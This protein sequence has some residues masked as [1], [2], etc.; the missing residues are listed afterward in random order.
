MKGFL[1][2]TKG[3]IILGSAGVLLAAVIALII[4]LI[5]KPQGYRSISV[6]EV[7]GS[8]LAEND[9]KAYSAYE[10]MRIG[11][12]YA[13]ITETDSYTRLILD[14]DKY[15][16]LEQLSRATFKELGTENKRNTVIN[17]VSGTL[18][19]EIVKPLKLEE[20]Y[21]IN[22]PNAVLSVRGTYFRTEVKRDTNGDY[23]TDVYT[24]GGTVACRR[25]MPDGSIV[26]EEVLIG[27]GYKAC[28][29]MDEIITV[30]VEELIEEGED[31]VD[32]FNIPDMVD[33]DLVGA[34]NASANGH[35]MFRNTED[36]WNEI[37]HRDIDLDKYKSP[38]DNEE[39]PPYVK[40][41]ETSVST[42]AS[43][44]SSEET[45]ASSSSATPASKGTTTV[46]STTVP[47]SG[48]SM[49]SGDSGFSDDTAETGDTDN[50]SETAETET[51]S[52]TTEADVQAET[53]T[54]EES[55]R[56]ESRG[57]TSVSVTS[58]IVTSYT[59][60]TLTEPVDD[61]YDETDNSDEIDNSVTTT[62]EENFVEAEEESEENIVTE[63]IDEDS[64]YDEDF[65][66]E[67]DLFDYAEPEDD[68]EIITPSDESR[69]PTV[70]S[71][72]DD[73]VE[74]M[75]STPSYIYTGPSVTSGTTPVTLPADD[76]M[77]IGI[78]VITSIT[79]TTTT[80]TTTTVTSPEAIIEHICVFENYISDNNATCTEDGTKT[81]VCECGKTD[82]VTDE[83]S[84][85]G[86]T[87]KS[88]TTEA[89]CTEAGKTV[90]SCETCGEVISETEIPALGHTEVEETK[91]ATFAETGLYVK[92]CSVCDELLDRK[93]L[94]RL[95]ALYT[96]DGDITITSTGYTQG[97]AAAETAFTD[98]YV[99]SQ[100]DSSTAV[101]CAIAIES[102]THN[103]K[104]DGVNIELT[105]KSG[106]MVSKDT[107]VSFAGTEALN[108]I[109]ICDSDIN[110]VNG[111]RN[112][113]KV[114]FSSGKFKFNYNKYSGYAVY[115]TD[116][117]LTIDGGAV[118]IY[119]ED[120]GYLNWDSSTVINNGLLSVNASIDGI[121]NWD[122]YFTLNGGEVHAVSENDN[123]IYTDNVF[124][125]NNGTLTAQGVNGI[126]NSVNFK[127]YNGRV[128]L[129]GSSKG[130]NNIVSFY[131][132]ED[133]GS[134]TPNGGETYIEGGSV[135]IFGGVSDI[136]NKNIFK[137]SGGSVRLA[138]D[139]VIG[140]SPII[141][142][143]T[144][145][146]ECVIY[147]TFPT[148][149]ERTFTNSD[150]TSY[151]YALDEADKA[152]DGKYYIWKPVSVT[153]EGL[154]INAVNFPD[155]VFRTYVSNNF[156]TDGNGYLSDE[157]IA[158]VTKIDVSGSD[159]TDGGV[160]SLTGIEHFTALDTLYCKF[161]G[162]LTSLDTS[163][164]TL[165]RDINCYETGITAFDFSSNT[166]LTDINVGHTAIIELDVT[167]NTELTT[168][169]FGTNDVTAI[170][171]SD[172]TKLTY[173]NCGENPLAE[174]DV[175]SNPDLWYLNFNNTGV[176]YID[177]SN[178]TELLQIHCYNCALT[179]ADLTNNT[180]LGTFSANNNK[181]SI[182]SNAVSFDT[183]LLKDFDPTKVSDVTNA[184]FDAAAGVFRMIT[185]DVTYTYDCGQ[186]FAPTFTLVRTGEAT[187]G[188]AVD[189]VNFPD[190]V[191]RNYVSDNFDTDGSG[192]LSDSEVAA[193]TEIDVIGE[194]IYS[195][196]GVEYFTELQKLYCMYTGITSLDVSK[197]TALTNLECD[198][199][200]ITNLDLSKNTA[201]TV[202]YC[203]GTGITS[204]DVSN[205]TVL[206]TLNCSG[207]AL[208]YIDLTNN[209]NLSMFTVFDSKY[210]IPS[211]ATTFDT[212]TIDG[213]DPSK[214]SD[215]T[216]ADLDADT[217]IF[218]N[219]TDD[220]TYTYDCGQGY[221]ETFTL[222]RTGEAVFD[223]TLY[224]EDGNINITSTGVTQG[225][226]TEETAWTGDY[227]ISQR[228]SSTE[229]ECA[230]DITDAD[231]TLDG[232]N[233]TST[234]SNSIITASGKRVT[235]FGTD[236]SNVISGKYGITSDC[237]YTGDGYGLFLE[238][239]L[240]INTTGIGIEG[241]S[242]NTTMN[243]GSISI[244]SEESSVIGIAGCDFIINDG[245]LKMYL[246]GEASEGFQSGAIINGGNVEI[247][248]NGLGICE[249][250]MTG[251]IATIS[252]TDLDVGDDSVI[253]GGSLRLI[254]NS[255]AKVQNETEM[256]YSVALPCTN[257]TTVTITDNTGVI[258]TEYDVN[259]VH[260]DG[261]AY[262]WLPEGIYTIVSDGITYTVTV[263]P[264]ETTIT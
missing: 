235:I 220:I 205:N 11:G 214:V 64:I 24:Y 51:S 78:P 31:K 154:E 203:G 46:I 40:K 153:P 188:I 85:T 62:E 71:T 130:I 197:N 2:T 79:T 116:A 189:S 25:I 81:A 185:G 13:L 23:Y 113:G 186:G 243:S 92:Y 201:L 250:N 124:I 35:K 263:T 160:A 183:S 206:T 74:P 99:I 262:I 140:D 142:N 178:N 84:A 50:D 145:E 165:L 244:Y 234:S 157:E 48:M 132:V 169:I 148:E 210:V 117:S 191:F 97:E 89:T 43:E 90:V 161:N 88:T 118:E 174:L 45:F 162:A 168:L 170:D 3:K 80:T 28:V 163:K 179:C 87:E 147:D 82:T 204:L 114:N 190:E 93:P 139:T 236:K 115:N 171:L 135:F 128:N 77:P 75:I 172:N 133:D 4:F 212:S 173:L 5:N 136:L 240:T 39:I 53:D 177:V 49:S 57:N 192:Y 108:T 248:A 103:V 152:D 230:I 251:G 122:G 14:D 58:P 216:G 149:A 34:Y 202:L 182:P 29:K 196:Q 42:S 72:T 134:K 54:S 187:E 228:D 86:H 259:A 125:V 121:Y 213:F 27:A 131:V 209:I 61:D 105:G 98:D 36:F 158:A 241:N 208:A 126:E 194:D 6:S 1:K 254:N 91:E 60:S 69:D 47:E 159:T 104:L 155:E 231:I 16:R 260:D 12:G 30:Y 144:D 7:Y 246:N 22:T 137:V 123:G 176:S 44:I 146:L 65:Y 33:D 83:G 143:G 150:G 200:G 95:P 233:I 199:T 10:N 55:R 229:V 195:L 38:Y 175:S 17:L 237:S 238:T 198:S 167:A 181:Y 242:T 221:S 258:Y 100:R 119:S 111:L 225:S 247:N 41:E 63:E 19:T 255:F 76:D 245:F 20:E 26:D 70:T 127:I 66:D 223:G 193:V 112:E 256:V 8:V 180:K 261:Y 207:S 67:D 217:G 96:E 232:I 253:T 18:T 184:E 141:T 106:I 9:G 222:T 32:P 164:N 56:S 257:P 226:A 101:D 120:S 129:K 37:D 156:D 215:V 59:G 107:N 219:I 239:N 15:I 252:G 110:K 94:E 264:T 68:D 21:V 224:T 102:G 151:I 138:N 52:V 109:T 73:D 218:T 227:I 211:N 166:A 249:L